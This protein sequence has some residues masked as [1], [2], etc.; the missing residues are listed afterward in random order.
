MVAA[1]QFQLGDSTESGLEFNYLAFL[2]DVI[3]VAVILLENEAVIAASS[4]RK[5]SCD[6]DAMVVV[7]AL[8]ELGRRTLE[9]ITPVAK[10]HTDN[11]IGRCASAIAL[12]AREAV[13]REAQQIRNALAADLAEIEKV[14][15]Q[16]RAKNADILDKL[17]RTHDLPLAEKI[18]EVMF[19]AG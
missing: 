7:G 12:A 10:E 5:K 16:L 11:A 1:V 9:M 3:D 17:L 15:A 14:P 6:R 19:V 4:E 13:E 8:G 18:H 2:K